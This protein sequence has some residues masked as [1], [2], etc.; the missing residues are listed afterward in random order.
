M[1][2]SNWVPMPFSLTRRPASRQFFFFAAALLVAFGLASHHF[3]WL[4]AL[5][6]LVSLWQIIGAINLGLITWGHGRFAALNAWLWVA[7]AIAALLLVS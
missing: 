7:L 4:F 6:G 3:G 1:N 2:A 5:L